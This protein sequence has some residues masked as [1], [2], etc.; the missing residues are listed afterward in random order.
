[1][2]EAQPVRAHWWTR[3][4]AAVRYLLDMEP[5]AVAAVWRAVLVLAAAVGLT[6]PDVV[7]SRV[8]AGIVAFYALVEV[9]TTIAARR[10]S[11][12]WAGAVEVVQDGQRI[13]GEAS[14][15]ATGTVLGPAPTPPFP[16]S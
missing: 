6:V 16:P 7:D 10:R 9:V 11:T 5:V 3:L 2:H 12:P 14:P 4:G 1:M 13:A 15:V 8:T